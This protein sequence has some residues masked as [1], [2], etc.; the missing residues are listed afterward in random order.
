MSENG[1]FEN[2]SRLNLDKNIKASREFFAVKRAIPEIRGFISNAVRRNQN[3]E[4]LILFLRRHWLNLFARIFP[5]LALI[6][7]IIIFF[8]II[9]PFNIVIFKGGEWELL[10]F[11][12]ALFSLFVW[13]VLFV[14]LVD[15]YLDIWIVTDQRIINIEQRGLFKREISELRILNVQDVTTDIGGIIPTLYDY[16][17]LYVQTAGKRERFLFRR[18]PHPG[19]V[20][21]V[22]VILS[23]M[24]K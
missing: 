11:F 3:K 14:R 9:I 22:V 18:I 19:R 10:R 24:N 1:I 21:D 4:T 8:L 7:L 5:M 20:R 15:Y 16:G 2:L 13:A 17:D 12:V 6:L 23:E